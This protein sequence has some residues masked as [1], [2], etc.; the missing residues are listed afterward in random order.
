MNGLLA[1]V[2]GL[3]VTGAIVAATAAPAGK[4]FAG[5][6]MILDEEPFWARPAYADQALK[7]L[8]DAGFNAYSPNVW[9]GRGATWPSELAPRDP[10]LKD[11]PAGGYDPLREL[12]RKAHGMG[13]QIHAWFNIV[14][15]QSDLRPELALPG[16][17]SMGDGAF[18]VHDP[19]FREW[20]SDVVAEVAANYDVDGIMLDYVRAVMVCTTD[21]CSRD[22]RARHDRDLRADALVMR[23]APSQVP[24]LVEYQEEA[25]TFLVKMI[26]EK[27]R[28]AK[29][30]LLLSADAFPDEAHPQDGQNSLAWLNGGL[31]DVLFRMD[32]A[33]SVNAALTDTLRTRLQRPDALSVMVSNVSIEERRQDQPYFS[34]S[35]K[36]LADTVSL[37]HQRW[38]RSGVAIYFYKWLSDEQIAA[39]K[40]GPF[41]MIGGRLKAPSRLEAR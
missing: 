31:I 14:L 22:Y 20:I 38:P 18:D 6:R 40:D 15:R 27:V 28:A 19:L 29:P 23:A 1:A 5:M 41:R 13:L 9:H 26:S 24:T 21:A 30:G 16:T 35:G 3:A 34:R 7:R 4:T 33:V 8:K 37:I 12:I 17:N 36:W 11:L 39:L 2:L 10:W 32:Y 25:V